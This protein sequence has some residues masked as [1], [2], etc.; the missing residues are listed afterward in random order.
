MS[1]VP[2][3]CRR[4]L[5]TSAVVFGF[6]SGINAQN[7]SIVKPSGK[8][9]ITTDFST[10]SLSAS[11]KKSKKIKKQDTSSVKVKRYYSPTRALWMSAVVPGLGQIYTRRYWK[12]PIVYAGLGVAAYFVVSNQLNYVVARD[13]YRAT[14]GVEGY[15]SIDPEYQ[16]YSPSQIKSFRDFYRRNRDFSIV[17]LAAVYA[18]NIIDATV[19]AHLRSFDVS[20]NLALKL[21]P[22]TGF[23]LAQGP[24]V[25]MS[26]TLTIR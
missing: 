19:D 6:L 3:R 20:D 17:A 14:Q 5:L 15:T 10:D 2:N 18:L 12:L 11:D 25:G 1:E 16:A 4:L 23:S 9:E 13:S 21:R 8:L 26:A 7:D 24:F 22:G